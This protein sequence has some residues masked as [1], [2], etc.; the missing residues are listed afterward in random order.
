MLFA[1]MLTHR[2]PDVEPSPTR[3][4]DLALALMAS[5]AL[6]YIFLSA[7]WTSPEL[8]PRRDAPH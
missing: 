2:D 1:V 3:C 6:L 4:I 5:G 8:E 7:I